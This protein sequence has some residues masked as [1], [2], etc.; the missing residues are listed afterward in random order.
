MGQLPTGNSILLSILVE[1]AWRLTEQKA[2]VAMNEDFGPKTVQ[3]FRSASRGRLKLYR[4]QSTKLE[5]VVKI[6]DTQVE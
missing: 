2:V 1:K 3:I 4:E 5:T 6:Q